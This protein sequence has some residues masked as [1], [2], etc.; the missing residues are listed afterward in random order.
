[1]NKQKI[2]GWNHCIKTLYDNKILSH[3]GLVKVWQVTTPKEKQD[4]YFNKK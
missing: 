4:E 1:M 3:K 2:L